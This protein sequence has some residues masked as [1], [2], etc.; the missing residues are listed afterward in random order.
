MADQ[1]KNISVTLAGIF[2]G[3]ALV[4]CCFQ[5]LKGVLFPLQRQ[6]IFHQSYT[7]VFRPANDVL[8][9]ADTTNLLVIKET[10]W[11]EMRRY[12]I[13]LSVSISKM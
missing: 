11:E 12:K 8:D 1:I 4:T 2:V 6:R 5:H 10:R 9:G 3:L 13:T 7:L